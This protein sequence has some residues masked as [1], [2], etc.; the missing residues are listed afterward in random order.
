MLLHTHPSK[1]LSQIHFLSWQHSWWWRPPLHQFNRGQ[2][3]DLTSKLQTNNIIPFL[4]RWPVTVSL[5]VCV[6]LLGNVTVKH[7]TVSKSQCHPAAEV[8]CKSSDLQNLLRRMFCW[9]LEPL[10]LLGHLQYATVFYTWPEENPCGRI[11][12]FLPEE[13][14]CNLPPQAWCS[15]PVN[16]LMVSHLWKHDANGKERGMRVLMIKAKH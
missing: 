11:V 4:D 12:L 8:C 2:S 15:C 5:Y 10:L 13:L 7:R 14:L 1:C 6:K 16:L 3:T 9:T